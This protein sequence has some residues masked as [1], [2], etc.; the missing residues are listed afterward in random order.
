VST[1]VQ[2]PPPRT[3][4]K[5]LPTSQDRG[6]YA[7]WCVIATEAM[8]FAAMFASYYYLGNNKDRWQIERAPELIY[9]WVMF[10]IILLSNLVMYWGHRQ[11]N[12]QCFGSARMAIWIAFLL[13]AGFFAVQAFEMSAH[14][15]YLT[16]MSDSYGSIFYTI[17]F[18]FIFHMLIGMLLLGYVGVLP[19]Y[20]PTLRSPHKPYQT[21]ATYWYFIGALWLFI[22]VFLYSVPNIQRMYHGR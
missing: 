11:V 15:R 16:P 14:W 10:G 17:E 7:T 2:I 22:V 19:N 3:P 18:L 1:L 8:L 4:L 5:A 21:A 20:A 6:I 12:A 13:G 9:P